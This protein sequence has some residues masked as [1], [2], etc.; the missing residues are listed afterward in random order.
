M[1]RDLKE[2]Q[3]IQKLY[4]EQVSKPENL[5]ER[6]G[7]SPEQLKKNRDKLFPATPPQ[8]GFGGGVGNPTNQRGTGFPKDKPKTVTPPETKTPEPKPPETK[9]TEPKGGE[10]EPAE[11][12]P[13]STKDKFNAKFIKK[14]KGK[15]FVRRGTPNAQRAE[16]IEK[17]K[18]RA[19][20]MAKAR[21]AKK[22]ASMSEGAL[23]E[24]DAYDL[25]LEYL[26]ST[27]QVATIEEANYVMTEMDAETIQG[28]VEE[29]KKNSMKDF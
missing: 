11:P 9:P 14:V 27:E 7:S 18:N 8:K 12:K 10:S 1:F 21:I 22:K 3:D 13:M 6:R 4:E 19:K 2:Y 15:G 5:E 29:Q 24:Y 25:V 26:L 17:N 20:E 23:V 28:I 16:N